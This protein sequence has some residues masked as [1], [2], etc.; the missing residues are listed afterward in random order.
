MLANLILRRS[1]ASAF[2][3]ACAAHAGQ[4]GCLWPIPCHRRREGGRPQTCMHFSGLAHSPPT[5]PTRSL[6]L[7][8]THAS[9]DAGI[10]RACILCPACC[11]AC[12]M[13]PCEHAYVVCPAD[14]PQPANDDEQTQPVDAIVGGD[15]Q[16][17]ARAC[18]AGAPRS[19]P[20]PLSTRSGRSLTGSDHYLRTQPPCKPKTSKP[21]GSKPTAESDQG[22]Q[23]QV[24]ADSVAGIRITLSQAAP[25]SPSATT[26]K[27]QTI[28]P[29]PKRPAAPHWTRHAST[30]VPALPQHMTPPALCN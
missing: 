21:K 22:F 4:L 25:R 13:C 27:P 23:D 5:R 8:P 26:A 15:E 2:G 20:S 3:A 12:M 24:N 28:P 11:P 1:S 14:H 18:R 16:Q 6:V 29:H 30:C 17:R 9:T 19:L 7:T 10:E